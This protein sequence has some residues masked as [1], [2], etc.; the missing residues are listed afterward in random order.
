MGVWSPIAGTA[1]PSRVSGVFTSAPLRIYYG[2]SRPITVVV[3]AEDKQAEQRY[4]LAVT[5]VR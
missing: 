5:R 1:P 4:T 3:L 2:R